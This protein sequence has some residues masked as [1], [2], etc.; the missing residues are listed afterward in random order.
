MTEYARALNAQQVVVLRW[1][2]DGCPAG[3]ME[4]V[5][6]RISASALK[7]RGLLRVSGHGKTWRAEITAAGVAVLEAP[8]SDE[9]RGRRRRQSNQSRLGANV[10]NASEQDSATDD[11]DAPIA[12]PRAL[13]LSKTEQLIADVIAA[14]GVLRVQGRRGPGEPDYQQ[15]ILSAQRFGKVPAGKHLH[16]RHVAG[17]LEIL[18]EDA[19]EGTDVEAAPVTVPQRV[20]RLHP[21][22]RQFRDQTDWHEVS[23]TQLPRCL[24]ILQGLVV[25]AERRDYDVA[26]VEASTGRDAH[27][28]SS[29]KSNGH[30][31]IAI[32]GH[33]YVLRITEEKV[34]NRGVW[35]RETQWRS[36]ISNP[37]YLPRRKL[38]R[39]DANGTGRLTITLGSGYAREGRPTSWSDRRS[40]TL[41]Q[42][43]PDLLRELEIRA[44]EDDDSKIRA[45]RAAQQRQRQWELAMERAKASFIEA[46]RAKS[47]RA[48]VSA[49]HEAQ[50]TAGYLAALEEAHGETDAAAAWIEWIRGYV[51]RLDPLR[52]LPTMPETPDISREDLK[53]FLGGLSPYGP[54]GW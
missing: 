54:S 24:R 48:Q 9:L 35:D 19:P 31:E 26:N 39:Y 14:G 11:P 7:S 8:P 34:V 16:K 46:H 45:E 15:R 25:E 42:K 28:R 53:P 18:L 23:R 4:G 49:W 27:A 13:R 32:R 20:S 6:H 5:A 47:L 52:S 38:S 33:R 30:L 44:A 3:V 36:S 2:A 1:V 37:Q 41:E 21:V 51:E 50:T 10:E 17:E 12:E 40:G 43:L 29:S 22:V